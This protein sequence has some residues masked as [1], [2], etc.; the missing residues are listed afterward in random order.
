MKIGI[1]GCG[2]RMGRTLLAEVLST[3]GVNLAAGAERAGDA[4]VGRDLGELAG[5][6]AIGVKATDDIK[7]LFAAADVVIDFTMPAATANN[8]KLAATMR[9]AM[10]I[11]TTGLD[12]YETRAIEEAAQTIPIMWSANMSIGVNVLLDMVARAAKTLDTSYDIEIVEMHHHHKVDSPSG[13]A[14][15]LGKAA[16]SGRGVKLDDVWRK[17]RD[18]I[19]G[20]RPKGEIGFATLR[21]GDVVG[22]HT[23][24]FAADGERIEFSHRA[25]SRQVFAK[26]AV[27]AAAWLAGKPAKL[28]TMKDVLGLN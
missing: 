24:M 8:A 17:T 19:V 5:R 1:A 4:A 10:V 15:A 2:G 16:A 26:G 20:A 12:A 21:G 6:T 23:V 25:S 28:Y 18:G 9:K 3:D 27:R 13:T 14:L 22:D 11:G 7:A